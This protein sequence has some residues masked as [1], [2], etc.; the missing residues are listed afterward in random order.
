MIEFLTNYWFVGLMVIG[1]AGYVIYLITKHRWTKL[2]EIAY[3]MIVQA[4]QVITGTKKGQER[5]NAVLTQL[6]NVIP[7]WLRIFIPKNLLEKKLQ[8]WYELIKDSLDDG[9]IN[10]ST[11]HSE[12]T[13]I[14][15][16]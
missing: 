8:Q 6:Y 5:F 11:A 4:E 15:N 7:L 3:K 1:F 16:L 13:D 10:H 14:D 12:S 9:E 2:R